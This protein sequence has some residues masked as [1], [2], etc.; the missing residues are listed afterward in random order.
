MAY[1]RQEIAVYEKI[2]FR[3]LGSQLGIA[4]WIGVIFVIFKML[5]VLTLSWWW[6]TSPFWIGGLHVL[7]GMVHIAAL[8]TA[9][10][11]AAKQ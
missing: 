7:A 4:F 9:N 5:D 2:R 8:R 3:A 11:Q 10:T 1:T 6:T